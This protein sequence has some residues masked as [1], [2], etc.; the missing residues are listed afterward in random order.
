MRK[1][2]FNIIRE[3][4]IN[5]KSMI[6]ETEDEKKAFTNGFKKSLEWNNIEDG[7]PEKNKPV[8]TRTNNYITGGYD[9]CMI[10]NVYT[11]SGAFSHWIFVSIV[12]NQEVSN[13][14]F[15]RYIETKYS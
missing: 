15:W 6:Y 5:S 9:I 4:S 8:F 10:E 1:I 12:T 13:V 14:R 3:S 11:D 2:N 7:Y